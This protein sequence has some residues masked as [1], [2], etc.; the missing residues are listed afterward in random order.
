[1]WG[2]STYTRVWQVSTDVVTMSKQGGRAAWAV[3]GQL[4]GVCVRA[5]RRARPQAARRTLRMM[6]RRKRAPGHVI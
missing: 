5:A 6:A 2:P 1:M 4:R 3:G